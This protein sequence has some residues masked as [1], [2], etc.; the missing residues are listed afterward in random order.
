MTL[1]DIRDGFHLGELFQSQVGGLRDAPD[2]EHTLHVFGSLMDAGMA[3]MIGAKKGDEWCGVIAA[4]SMPDIFSAVV[5]AQEVLWYVH[6]DHRRI[7][8]HLFNAFE[9]WGRS[10]GAKY[11]CCAHMIDSMPES[12]GHFY[13]KRGYQLQDTLYRKEA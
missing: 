6:P 13:R 9:N 11:L 10:K 1:D 3:T 5:A 8:A 12:V 4:I 7:G 2:L